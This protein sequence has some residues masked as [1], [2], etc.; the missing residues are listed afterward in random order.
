MIFHEKAS[1]GSYVIIYLL[2]CPPVLLQQLFALFS[3]DIGFY[4]SEKG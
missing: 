4:T 3:E 1:F 2:R